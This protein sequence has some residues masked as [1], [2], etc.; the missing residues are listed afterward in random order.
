MIL[1]VIIT[2]CALWGIALFMI[3]VLCV[4]A[5]V[6]PDPPF[7]DTLE[8]EFADELVPVCARSRCNLPS[9]RDQLCEGHYD[10]LV[11]MTQELRRDIEELSL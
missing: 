6:I 10:L 11:D 8:E 1:A 9:Y 2:A 4:C 7:A 3:V 5:A